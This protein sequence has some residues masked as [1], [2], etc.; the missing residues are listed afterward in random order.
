MFR[1]TPIVNDV[2]YTTQMTDGSWAMCGPP[3]LLVDQSSAVHAFPGEP[4]LNDQL[5]LNRPHLD[6]VKFE[7]GDEEYERVLRFLFEIAESAK[8]VVNKRLR[9]RYSKQADVTPAAGTRWKPIS[10]MNYLETRKEM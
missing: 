1:H 10:E 2:Y 4:H 3:V 9:D 8:E 7:V 6:M 5:A